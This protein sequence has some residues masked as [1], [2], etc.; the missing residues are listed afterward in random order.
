MIRGAEG[1]GEREQGDE[2]EQQREDARAV[3]HNGLG[4][5]ERLTPVEG[6]Y[7][8]AAVEELQHDAD[9][10]HDDQYG[11]CRA[12]EP[13]GVLRY[14]GADFS[15]VAA[16]DEAEIGR[17]DRFASQGDLDAVRDR[18]HN[19]DRREDRRGNP[20]SVEEED[21]HQIEQSED[22][23]VQEE[24]YLPPSHIWLTKLVSWPLTLLS[25]FVVSSTALGSAY[26][27]SLYTLHWMKSTAT[28]LV[29]TNAI[30]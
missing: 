13:C 10:H 22:Q 18:E 5:P 28:A 9:D 4:V 11:D 21:Q 6:D 25:I 3:A 23:E 24:V 1:P 19:C 17:Q 16:G 26:V 8:V 14:E 15:A 27:G 30:A 12:D 7:V 2:A 29:I 20:E